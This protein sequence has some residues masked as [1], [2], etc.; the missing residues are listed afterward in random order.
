M[1]ANGGYTF[2]VCETADQIEAA[3]RLRYEVYCL[4][5]GWIDPGTCD[6]GMESDALDEG[7][8]HFLALKDGVPVGTVRAL[9]GDTY[10]L[11]AAKFLPLEQFD[12]EPSQ[13]AEVSRLAT[14][15]HHG[16]AQN[17]YVFI[18]LVLLMWEWAT[19]RS[20][21]VWLAVIDVPLYHLL[22]R[23][24]MPVIAEGEEVEYIGSR[25]VPVAFDM[26][27]TGP[28]LIRRLPEEERA[29]VWTLAHRQ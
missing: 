29:R 26:P 22:V 4:E 14:L 18:R 15:R 19:Q 6:E 7:A 11:P 5:K 21:K 27:D 9:P 2:L 25:C 10:D 24:G 20:I 17:P 1:S 23:M 28:A 13:I 3:R 8:V 12:V 16:R